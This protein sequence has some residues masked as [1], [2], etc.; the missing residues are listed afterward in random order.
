M[1]ITKWILAVALLSPPRCRQPLNP[2][3]LTS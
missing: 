3:T 1:Q 2:P